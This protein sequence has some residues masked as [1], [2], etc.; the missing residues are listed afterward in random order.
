MKANL[1]RQEKFHERL[2]KVPFKLNHQFY[3]LKPFWDKLMKDAGQRRYGA[4]FSRA[5]HVLD[6]MQQEYM[7]I[8]DEIATQTVTDEKLFLQVKEMLK[9][10]HEP[11]RMPP[12]DTDGSDSEPYSKEEK[13]DGNPLDERKLS[14]VD[15]TDT[16]SR[17]EVA[18]AIALLGENP[19][20]HHTATQEAAKEPANKADQSQSKKQRASTV[21]TKCKTLVSIL[22]TRNRK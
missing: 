15:E 13:I 20:L 14:A 10:E 11:A 21:G 19:T 4:E 3:S 7:E 5:Q 22:P 1:E 12:V 18:K 16:T 2:T 9:H 6:H 17:K 8:I